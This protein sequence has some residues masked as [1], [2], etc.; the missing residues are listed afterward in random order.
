MSL[1]Q[2]FNYSIETDLSKNTTNYFL[3]M[4]FREVKYITFIELS[5]LL[6]VLNLVRFIIHF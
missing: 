2:S 3:L 5:E 1:I 6:D 4:V